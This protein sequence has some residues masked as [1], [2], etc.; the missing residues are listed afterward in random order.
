MKNFINVL[1][2]FRVFNNYLFN[3]SDDE[4]LALIPL[5]SNTWLLQAHEN[6]MNKSLNINVIYV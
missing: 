1:L 2:R 5:S 3:P 6:R 4:L